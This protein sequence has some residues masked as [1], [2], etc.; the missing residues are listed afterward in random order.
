MQN[1]LSR[2][3]QWLTQDELWMLI[4][5]E[6]SD[7][8]K[9]KYTKAVKAW[10]DDDKDDKEFVRNLRQLLIVFKSK[11]EKKHEKISFFFFFFMFN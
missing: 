11:K 8:F 5:P 9:Y 10:A 6:Y 3:W 7:L 4:T 2:A 1:K